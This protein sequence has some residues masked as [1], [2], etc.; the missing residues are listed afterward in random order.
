MFTDKKVKEMSYRYDGTFNS[1]DAAE[2][3][4]A[5]MHADYNKYMSANGV[6]QETL[7]PVFSSH[8]SKLVIS[9][10]A[11]TKKINQTIAKLFFIN[12]DEYKKTGDFTLEDFKKF[13]ELRGFSCKNH[14]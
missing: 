3:A 10:Y 13:Y 2:S 5:A 14:D 6:Y 7:N 12:D 8:K 1:D 11:E 4:K 9:L